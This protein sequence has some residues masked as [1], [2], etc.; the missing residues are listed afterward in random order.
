MM[1]ATFVFVLCLA[2]AVAAGCTSSGAPNRASA[3]SAATAAKG[4]SVRMT[5]NDYRSGA[6]FEL[7][8]RSHTDALD[9][10]SKISS[11]AS[12]KVQDDELMTALRDYLEDEGFEKLAHSGSAPTFSKDTKAWTLELADAKGT[13]H[14][15]A[16]PQT[17]IED[18]KA[19]RKLLDA[20]LATYNETQGWQAVD[21]KSKRAEDYFR[22]KSS[23]G[24]NP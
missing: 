6:T 19:M 5:I 3:D 21:I 11:S 16:T 10:Y 12:R 2:T 17:P 23:S 1:R 18:M 13:R 7:V 22:A 24:K 9:Q 14:V 8:N 15:V 20:V 4:E